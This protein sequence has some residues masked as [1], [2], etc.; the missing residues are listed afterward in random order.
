MLTIETTQDTFFLKKNTINCKGK[1]LNL[2]ELVVMGILNLTPDSFFD[3]GLLNNN[4]EIIEK[5]QKML[6][7][8]A[9]IIDI[10]GYSSRPGAAEVSEKDELDR[11]IPIIKLLIKQF[12]EIII[13]IDTFRSNVAKQAINAGAAIINDISAGNM[14]ANMFATVKELQVPYIIMHMQ[15]TPQTM[16]EKPTYKNVT[17]EVIDFFAKKVNELNKLGINDIIIDPGFGFGKTIEHNYELLNHLADFEI[18][19][20]PVLVGFSRKSMIN[21]V[22][23]TTPQEALNGTTTLNTLAL[24]K[25]AK[26]L[27]VHDVLEAKQVVDLYKKMKVNTI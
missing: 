23:K 17:L 24:S 26:I 7:D 3:G 1:L 19:E 20:L 8:G 13:S 5:V 4:Q 11:V 6:S 16:Q 15:G 25:G 9:T 22:I 18:L 14:D 10:G 27:R 12:P 2:D 21:K